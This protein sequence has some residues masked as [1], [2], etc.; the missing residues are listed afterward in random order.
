M[1]PAVR[2]APPGTPPRAAPASPLTRVAD[3]YPRRF[4]PQQEVLDNYILTAN[5]RGAMPKQ[6]PSKLN[7]TFEYFTSPYEQNVITWCAPG[8]H[9]L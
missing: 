4:A 3:Y 6:V 7:G 1:R 5:S 2:P 8:L 9:S